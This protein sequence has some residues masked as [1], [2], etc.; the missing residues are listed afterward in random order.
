MILPDS[1][2]GELETVLGDDT[3]KYLNEFNKMPYRGIS[4][5][6]LKTDPDTLLPLLR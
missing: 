5:N 1:F 2:I 3:E 4:V 6:H